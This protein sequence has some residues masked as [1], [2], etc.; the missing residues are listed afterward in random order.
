MKK[1]CNKIESTCGTT[2]WA[3]CIIYEGTTNENSPLKDDCKLSVEESIEDIYTQL[4]QIN[5]SDLGE[6]CLTYV[7]EEGKIIVKNVLLKYEE[8]ICTLKEK[9]ETLETTSFGDTNISAMNLDLDCLALPCDTSITTV[10]DLFQ[11]L[12]NKS[13]E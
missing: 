2:N 3:T 8:E 7:L 12:I 9:V 11:A 1:N 4:E 13:C 5:L 10:K 6:K